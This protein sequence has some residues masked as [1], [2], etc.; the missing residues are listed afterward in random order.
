MIVMKSHGVKYK[1]I[2]NLTDKK[3][4]SVLDKSLDEIGTGNTVQIMLH[5]VTE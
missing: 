4:H 5:N 1:L 2:V 3:R